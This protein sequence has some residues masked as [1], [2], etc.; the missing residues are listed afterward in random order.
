MEIVSRHKEHQKD[1]ACE[2]SL[3]SLLSPNGLIKY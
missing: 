1:P 2:F 3:P